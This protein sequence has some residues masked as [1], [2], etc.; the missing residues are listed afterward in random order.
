MRVALA[1]PQAPYLSESRMPE[2]VATEAR[3]SVLKLADY[4]LAGPAERNRIIQNQKYPDNFITARYTRAE[5]AIISH[6]RGEMTAEELAERRDAILASPLNK[7]QDAERNALCA[8][9]INAALAFIPHSPIAGLAMTLVNP[10]PPRLFHGGV[11]I[12]VQPDLLINC[13]TRGRRP[14]H[15]GFLKLRLGKTEAMDEHAARLAAAVLHRYGEEFLD[16]QPPVDHRACL[17][18][19]VFHNVI[20]PATG[21]LVRNWAT[22]SAACVE[23]ATMWEVA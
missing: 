6:L 16:D 13:P 5:N 7:P 23:Y 17:V 3:I 10:R 4:C 8:Q 9:A 15:R 14:A 21:A 18:Y 2:A 1:H 12:S 22:I 19:D 20:H 11:S